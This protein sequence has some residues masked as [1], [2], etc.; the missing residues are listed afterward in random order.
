MSVDPTSEDWIDGY[1]TAEAEL[2]AELEQAR[3]ELAREVATGERIDR[4]TQRYRDA[5]ER[6]EKLTAEGWAIDHPY[7]NSIARLALGRSSYPRGNDGTDGLE[8]GHWA[9]LAG[10][11]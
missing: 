9:A 7:L 5:L 4:K 8:D 1:K 3:E 10:D 6:I 2:Q 11:K